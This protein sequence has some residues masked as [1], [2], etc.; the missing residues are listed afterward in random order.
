MKPSSILGFFTR[1]GKGDIAAD[2]VDDLPVKKAVVIGG[3]VV[4]ISSA[5]ELAKKGYSVLVLEKSAGP[6]NECSAVAAGGCQRANPLVNRSNWKDVFWSTAPFLS[7]ATS[8]DMKFFNVQ[9]RATLS[10]PHFFRWLSD[11]SYNSLA[12]PSVQYNRQQ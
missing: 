8:K 9:W 11:F 12:E 1:G 5:W 4:G 6:A 7:S 2:K 10:D 3:G